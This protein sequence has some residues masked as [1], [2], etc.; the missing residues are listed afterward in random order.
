MRP[1]HE[2]VSAERAEKKRRGVGN[3]E[4]RKAWTSFC[5]VWTVRDEKFKKMTR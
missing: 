5:V 1:G 4:K 3:L 2:A